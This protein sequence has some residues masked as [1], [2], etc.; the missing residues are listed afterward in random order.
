MFATAPPSSGTPKIA[1]VA[2]PSAA[3]LPPKI[4]PW[5]DSI[6]PMPASVFQ[7]MTH[8]RLSNEIAT[9]A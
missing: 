6:S 4:V 9:P 5:C 2:V 1:G 7:P 8:S 3:I